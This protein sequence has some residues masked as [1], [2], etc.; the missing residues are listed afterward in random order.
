MIMDMYDPKNERT[1]SELHDLASDLSFGCSPE[2][3]VVVEKF[4][5]GET[6][7]P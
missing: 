4:D 2:N 3:V 6:G 5:P 7:L 1:L